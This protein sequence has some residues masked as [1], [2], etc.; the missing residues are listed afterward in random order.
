MTGTRNTQT[1]KFDFESVNHESKEKTNGESGQIQQ[2]SNHSYRKKFSSV[3]DELR[4]GGQSRDLVVGD[5]GF[6]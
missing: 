1:A 6:T 5:L 4:N 3:R 2:P